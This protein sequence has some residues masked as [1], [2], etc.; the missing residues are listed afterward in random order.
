MLFG[1]EIIPVYGRE[2]CVLRFMMFTNLFKIVNITEYV[3]QVRCMEL[4]DLLEEQ[5]LSES[6]IEEKVNSF[7][8]KLLAEK[9]LSYQRD[10]SGRPM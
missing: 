8:A 2:D 1:V 4:R 10:S 3:F 9:K 5:E 7:R 6:E